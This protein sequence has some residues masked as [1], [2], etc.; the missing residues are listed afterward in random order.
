MGLYK[1]TTWTYWFLQDM[2]DMG[3]ILLWE[4]GAINSIVGGCGPRDSLHQKHQ[5]IDITNKGW[6]NLTFAD[7]I[8]LADPSAVDVIM[9]NKSLH[10]HMVWVPKRLVNSYPLKIFWGQFDETSPDFLVHCVNSAKYQITK[11]TDVSM[12]RHNMA[13]PADLYP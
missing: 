2:W 5:C 10:A 11:W 13:K 1:M 4:T 8:K 9:V 12:K 6:K 3:D 7:R